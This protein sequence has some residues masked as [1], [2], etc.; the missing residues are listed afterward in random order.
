[1]GIFETVIITAKVIKVVYVTSKAIGASHCA[2][3]G[4][5]A[6]AS[7]CSSAIAR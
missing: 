2:S 3:I 7:K 1:M 5:H 6:A 4:S